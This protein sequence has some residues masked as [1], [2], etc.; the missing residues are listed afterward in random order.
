MNEHENAT[1]MRRL[2]EQAWTDN[3]LDVVDEIV[4][5]EFVFTRGGGVQEGG[6][7]LYKDLIRHT[8]EMF[9]DM[10]Y[11][12]D[13]V[14]VGDGGDAVTVRWTVT[15]THEG[16]YMGIEPTH[17]TIEMEGLELNRFEDGRL[18]EACTHP[19]WEGFLEDVGVLPLDD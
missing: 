13:E 9:P 15:A 16:E 1:Q 4:D 2:F 12:L 8:R 7:E 18:V 10:E 11:S 6:S 17:Q 5:E 14:I 19:H 3:N